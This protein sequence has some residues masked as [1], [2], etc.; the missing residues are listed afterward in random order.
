MRRDISDPE[1][2]HNHPQRSGHRTAAGWTVVCG[3]LGLLGL[4]VAVGYAARNPTIAT[5]LIPTCAV[6]VVGGV[7]G[8]LALRERDRKRFG[9]L[10][11]AASLVT[12]SAPLL[13]AIL[14]WALWTGN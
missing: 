6:L 5:M 13:F 12:L 3:A 4:V 7:F 10:T 11:I 1:S 8:V 14:R 2:S 9:R